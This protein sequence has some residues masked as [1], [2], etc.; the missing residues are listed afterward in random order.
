[1]LFFVVAVFCCVLSLVN[2]VGASG[3]AESNTATINVLVNF[4]QSNS[5]FVTVTTPSSLA[6][7]LFALTVGFVSV[8]VGAVYWVYRR[9]KKVGSVKV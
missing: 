8:G 5:S 1:L 4:A 6:A 2:F 3:S 7:P 9:L